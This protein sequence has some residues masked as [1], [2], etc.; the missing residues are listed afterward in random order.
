M[1]SPLFGRGGESS[2]SGRC[3]SRYSRGRYFFLFSR[4][5]ESGARAITSGWRFET[6]YFL[7]YCARPNNLVPPI[8]GVRYLF[9][10]FHRWTIRLNEELIILVNLD[11]R[12]ECSRQ[13]FRSIEWISVLSRIKNE[14]F[15]WNFFPGIWI[16]K[17]RINRVNLSRR[18]EP[19][20]KLRDEIPPR[21]INIKRHERVVNYFEQQR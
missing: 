6:A 15:F 9:S 13:G 19:V 16:W 8:T 7:R 2:H 14:N 10:R 20:E 21:L 5:Q 18:I 11:P 1:F 17:L 3:H 12:F 4:M